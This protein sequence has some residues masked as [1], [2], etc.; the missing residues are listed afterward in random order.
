MDIRA[1]EKDAKKFRGLLAL[2]PRE[3]VTV[4]V[5]AY[6]EPFIMAKTDDG[7]LVQWTRGRENIETFIAYG[8]VRL[9]KKCPRKILGKCDCEKCQWY[10]IQKGT[11]DCAMVWQAIFTA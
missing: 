8:Y 9:R 4:T 6:D 5:D 11:G 7:R 2:H 10:V 3:G 1:N